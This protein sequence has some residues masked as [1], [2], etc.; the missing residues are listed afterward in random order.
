MMYFP[1]DNTSEI[2]NWVTKLYKIVEI[3]CV[4]FLNALIVYVAYFYWK[5]VGD[6][7][8]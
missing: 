3:A 6:Y 1:E 2:E 5:S 4:N 7:K 8:R